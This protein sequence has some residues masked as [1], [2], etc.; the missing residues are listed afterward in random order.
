MSFDVIWPFPSRREHLFPLSIFNYGN[1]SITVG[2]LSISKYNYELL[3]FVS[4]AFYFIFFAYISKFMLNYENFSEKKTYTR[5][6]SAVYQWDLCQI[7]INIYI[8]STFST[9]QRI[10][11]SLNNLR[12]NTKNYIYYVSYNIFLL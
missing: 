12:I 3:L 5:Y 7:S 4:L 10:N 9:L 2:T 1:Y 8:F 6:F 11:S